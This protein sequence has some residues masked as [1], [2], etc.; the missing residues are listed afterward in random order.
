MK[1]CKELNLLFIILFVI[2]CTEIKT[3][4]KWEPDLLSE[5]VDSIGYS[6]FV[7]SIEYI[8]LETNDS[9]L[10]KKINDMAIGENHL[11]VLDK[12]Q[13]T[14]WIFD[15]EGRY[16]NKIYKKGN[17]PGEYS[18]MCQFEYDPK[19][20]QIVVLSSYQQKLL[21]YTLEGD[22][23]KTV[24]LG[25]KAQDFK[26]CPEG[27][28]ILSKAGIDDITAGIYHQSDSTKEVRQ[29]VGRQSNHLVYTTPLWELCS[30]GDVICFMAPNFNNAVYHYE[31]R[32]LSIKYPFQMKPDL[33]HEYKET[34]SLQHFEDFMRTV[35]LES[36]K[37]IYATYWS[38]VND[39]RVF[40]YSKEQ[41]KYWIG[42]AMVND[43]D[44]KG[45]GVMLSVT[46]NNIFVSCL[47]NENTDENPVIAISHL[48]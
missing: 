11:F 37:W 8:N 33:K 7:D 30:Y 38:S 32:Q 1:G 3:T 34:V 39:L 28:F 9:C 44:D 17:G 25:I 6:L 29:L 26:I 27:G 41:D 22:Y 15:R 2:S 12:P 46:D 35:Y 36:A 40:L 31:N 42:K 18:Q 43:L 14:I 23:I 45:T 13:Q 24:D 19:N 48:N 20:N 47:S 21:F 10:I 5:A 4:S 16:I